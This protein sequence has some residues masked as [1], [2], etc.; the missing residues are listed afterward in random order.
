V[1]KKNNND[2]DTEQASVNYNP[3]PGIKSVPYSYS[4][5]DSGITA[6]EVKDGE[7]PAGLKLNPTTG[8]IEGTPTET[9][10]PTKLTF[11]LTVD[12]EPTDVTTEFTV[13]E[14]MKVERFEDDESLGE[15]NREEEV[16]LFAGKKNKFVPSGGSGKYE[17]AVSGDN[18]VSP[19]GELIV[20]EPGPMTLTVI[21]AESG[22]QDV[23]NLLVSSQGSICGYAIESD[24]AAANEGIP[25]VDIITDCETPVTI[26][27]NALSLLRGIEAGE[28]AYREPFRFTDMEGANISNNNKYF[29]GFQATAV[30][31]FAVAENA[32]DGYPFLIEFVVHSSV[33]AATTIV[34]VGFAPNFMNGAKTLVTLDYAVGIAGATPAARKAG[35]YKDGVLVVGS[36]FA[37]LEGQQVGL[38][39]YGDAVVLYI[40]G[41]LKYTVT[42][43]TFACAG[44]DIVLFSSAANIIIGGAAANLTYAILTAGTAAQIGTINTLTGLYTPAE[45]NVGL[46]TIKGTNVANPLALYEA[47]VRVIK[48]AVKASFEKAMI[49]GVPIDMWVC[50]PTRYDELPLRLDR[51]GRPD[52]NQ[53]EDPRHLGTLAGSGRIETTP[54]RNEFRNDRGA[55]STS[56]TFDKVVISG[57]YLN[58]RDFATTKRLIPY[59]KELNSNGV[60]TLRQFSTGCQHKMR[61]LMIWATPDC[62]DVTVYD[63]IE[64]FNGLSYTPFTLEVG[65]TVQS[66]IALTIEGFP[67]ADSALFDY[68]QYN[69]HFIRI[70]S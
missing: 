7:L 50:G 59:M 70:G 6:A 62:G 27:F 15:V 3:P 33:I 45:Q 48:P 9:R 68:N 41:V 10:E 55:T 65:Q 28:T 20:N 52:R 42:G 63:A 19:E 37:V 53:V 29:A 69:Q 61:I 30:N 58:V 35:I 47:K 22:Q 14:P 40:D 4:P 67:N 23:I 34:A 54:T 39:V 21:D 18:M 12:G 31:G 38:A 66:Q 51:D 13:H 25:C 64:I 46:V 2:A 24:A 26:A 1:K 56:L 60:R 8:A 57:A 32:L 11:G 36:D 49:E 17:Y 43:S 5:A 16:T 44:T